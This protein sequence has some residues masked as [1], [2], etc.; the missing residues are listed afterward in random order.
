MK[1]QLSA[2]DGKVHF[3]TLQNVTP[4]NISLPMPETSSTSAITFQ[5]IKVEPS[6]S[7]E[8]IETISKPINKPQVFKLPTLS[9]ATTLTSTTTAQTKP[10][11]R[12][13]TAKSAVTAT[14]KP[15]NKVTV[16]KVE[17][18]DSN[19]TTPPT[20]GNAGSGATGKSDVPTCEICDKV[21]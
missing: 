11:V 19:T 13:S 7:P 1:D 16:V 21:H 6:T 14:S 18:S 12:K 3:T 17:G 15:N 8:R 2:I 5:R 10:T 9:N 20:S 4:A